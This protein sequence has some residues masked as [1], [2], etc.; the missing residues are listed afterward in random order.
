MIY[1]DK[2]DSIYFSFYDFILM[3]FHLYLGEFD[4]DAKVLLKKSPVLSKKKS[5]TKNGHQKWKQTSSFNLNTSPWVDF[6]KN[7]NIF[8]SGFEKHLFCSAYKKFF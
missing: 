3:Y 6:K 7:S 1:N 8:P 2:V 5:H 4:T